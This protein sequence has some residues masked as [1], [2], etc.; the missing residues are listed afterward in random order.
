MLFFGNVIM[1]LITNYKL[2][3]C[4]R[5]VQILTTHL[6]K[7]ELNKGGLEEKYTEQVSVSQ[8]EK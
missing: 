6:D 3:N 1:D 2:T 8:I 5:A 4:R 7:N